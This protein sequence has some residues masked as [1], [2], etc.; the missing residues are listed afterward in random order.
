MSKRGGIRPGCITGFC[1]LLYW[2]AGICHA[3]FEFSRESLP[4]SDLR[5]ACKVTPVCP[6]LSSQG[7]Q[8]SWIK[9]NG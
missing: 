5:L 2:P 7:T 3:P 8:N 4:D 9:T 1:D 6:T